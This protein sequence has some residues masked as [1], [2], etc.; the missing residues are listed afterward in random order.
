[1]ICLL[2]Q[3]R[4]CLDC[5]AFSPASAFCGFDRHAEFVR[6][7]VVDFC[8]IIISGSSSSSSCSTSSS[9]SCCCCRCCLGDRKVNTTDES[10][11]VGYTDDRHAEFIRRPIIV[12]ALEL[13][14]PQVVDFLLNFGADLARYHDGLLRLLFFCSS[15]G[16]VRRLKGAYSSSWEP[17]SELRSVICHMRLHSITC[18]RHR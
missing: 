10:H 13:C 4:S 11:F 9:S 7:H 12:S 3:T 1:M 18:T 8:S 2:G 14:T 5:L 16:R 6:R 15:N 17:T